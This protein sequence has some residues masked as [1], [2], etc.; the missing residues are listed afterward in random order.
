MFPW[1]N[2]LSDGRLSLSYRYTYLIIKSQ[3]NYKAWSTFRS[4]RLATQPTSRDRFPRPKSQP[5][6]R[7]KARRDIGRLPSLFFSIWWLFS[8]PAQPHKTSRNGAGEAGVWF[9]LTSC[10]VYGGYNWNGWNLTTRLISGPILS[11]FWWWKKD[12][13]GIPWDAQNHIPQVAHMVLSE[14]GAY[15]IPPSLDFIR[16]HIGKW[17]L[18]TGL[19]PYPNLHPVSPAARVRCQTPTIF[20]TNSVSKENF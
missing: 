8:S 3:K 12:G 6:C 1:T 5:R 10:G 15:R 4:S 14:N 2:S 9:F 7:T 19:Y 16:E 18:T 13:I 17:W 20:S 11:D